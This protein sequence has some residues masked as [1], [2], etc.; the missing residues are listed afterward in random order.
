MVEPTYRLLAKKVVAERKQQTL[1]VQIR[2]RAVLAQTVGKMGLKGTPGLNI[3]RELPGKEG[4][5]GGGGGGGRGGGGGGRGRG[6][7]RGGRGG[8]GRGQ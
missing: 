6:G 1:T 8:R 5:N 4:R 7:G 3:V 2:P